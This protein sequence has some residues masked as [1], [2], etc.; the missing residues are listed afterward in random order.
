MQVKRGRFVKPYQKPI[1][2]IA[3]ERFEVLLVAAAQIPQGGEHAI[4]TLFHDGLKQ[5]LL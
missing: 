1:A 2:K 4:A 3:Q 5:L